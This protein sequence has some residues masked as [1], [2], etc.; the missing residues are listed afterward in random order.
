MIHL[1]SDEVDD[2]KKGRMRSVIGKTTM[3]VDGKDVPVAP[4]IAASVGV[5]TGDRRVIQVFF[6]SPVMEYAR[7]N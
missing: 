2:E 7:E 1:G 4:G 5:K 6:L 3:Y